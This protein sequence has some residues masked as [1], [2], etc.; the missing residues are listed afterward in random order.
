VWE[1]VRLWDNAD[2]ID[3]HHEHR[4]TR[5]DGKQAPTILGFDS[6]NEAMAAALDKAKAEA[7]EMVRQWQRP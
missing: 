4:Y 3:E 6:V 1:T 7:P 2:A 5:T